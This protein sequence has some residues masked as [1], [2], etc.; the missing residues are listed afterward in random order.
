MQKSRVLV[1]DDEPGVREL[2]VAS[3]DPSVY[4]AQEAVDGSD[5]M[6]KILM[7]RPDLIILDWMMPKMSGPE[8]VHQVKNYPFTSHIPILMLTAKGQTEDKVEMLK[9]GA[10]DYMAKPFSIDELLARVEALLRK[11]KRDLFADE[12][13]GLPGPKAAEAA[14]EGL[15]VPGSIA[16]IQF[17]PLESYAQLEK[18]Q[19]INS[20]KVAAEIIFQQIV[21]YNLQDKAFLGRVKSPKLVMMV[22]GEYPLGF[23]EEVISALDMAFQIRR[24]SL[25]QQGKLNP[26]IPPLASQLAII[27]L[28]GPISL[29]A[30]EEKTKAAFTAMA[31]TLKSGYQRLS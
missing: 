24:M 29:E 25:V 22:P 19:E 13:T 12:E 5:A 4:D 16:L 11:T 20:L 30:L 18:D 1:V 3:L 10:D 23:I 6:N 17:A 14:L 21:K 2:I 7:D 8:L 31:S 28:K 9:M 15:S 26:A 27:E